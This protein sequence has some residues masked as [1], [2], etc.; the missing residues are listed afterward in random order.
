MKVAVLGAS[1]QVGRGLCERF[2]ELPGIEPVAIVRNAVGAAL[3]RALSFDLRIGDVTRDGPR[4]LAGC[5]AV[6]NAALASGLPHAARKANEAII[7]AIA[8]SAEHG[9]VRRCVVLSSVAVYGSC[10]HPSTGSTFARPSPTDSYGRD[11]LAAEAHARR[12]FEGSRVKLDVVRLGHVV[13]PHQVNSRAFIDLSQSPRF[14]LPFGGDK[15]SNTIHIA[16]LAPLLATLLVSERAGATYDGVDEPNATWRDVFA[17][18][19]EAAGLPAARTLDDA[20]SAALQREALSSER[21]HRLPRAL[22]RVAGAAVRAGV[23][24]FASDRDVRDLGHRVLVA[25]PVGFEAS[26]KRAYL[27]WSVRTHVSGLSAASPSFSIGPQLL[28]EASPGP[29]LGAL[30][31]G[32]FD[33]AQTR[34]S[35]AR[36]VD[37]YRAP[38]WAG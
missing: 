15:P 18:H 34:E 28:S 27:R 14:A 30:L 5:D 11:K 36:W 8:A 10:L 35:I 2:A 16:R 25:M 4:L 7:E 29:A 22:A 38:S 23:A 32:A 1:G 20:T 33:V 17:H 37:G 6:V 24:A 13:G 31:P 12:V 19:T 21:A 3:L 9:R 26:V